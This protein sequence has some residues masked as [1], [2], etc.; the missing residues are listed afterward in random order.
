MFDQY[1][2]NMG[3]PMPSVYKKF[4]TTHFNM[5]MNRP[6]GTYFHHLVFLNFHPNVKIALAS[7]P[8]SSAILANSPM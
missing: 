1:I 7:R 5:Y 6:K 3:F 8:K 2:F 4:P